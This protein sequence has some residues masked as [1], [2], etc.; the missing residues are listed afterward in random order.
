MSNNP[1]RFGRV[2]PQGIVDSDA[3]FAQLLN[4]R[5]S[6][7]NENLVVAPASCALSHSASAGSRYPDAS[8]SQRRRWESLCQVLGNAT[9]F[10]SGAYIISVNV[11]DCDGMSVRVAAA[12]R[13]TFQVEDMGLLPGAFT[14]P[15]A[16]EGSPLTH[17]VLFHFDDPNRYVGLDDTGATAFGN[18]IQGS[19]IGTDKTDSASLGN[20][21]DG[22]TV[23]GT[24]S[25]TLIG[26]PTGLGGNTIANN[27]GNGV[28]LRSATG[29]VIQGNR[30]FANSGASQAVAAGS[31]SNLAPPVLCCAEQ[32]LK[33]HRDSQGMRDR[34][35]QHSLHG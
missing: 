27:L 3:M 15:A 10:R 9:Y 18:I 32:C 1:Q 20:T 5:V 7:P 22:I 12:N 4:Q 24:P 21:G 26:D 8:K 6:L 34:G 17:V 28:Q 35:R 25:S 19:H 13:A 33:R 29:V 31:N 11:K 14:P 16:V 23:S 30:V 2:S